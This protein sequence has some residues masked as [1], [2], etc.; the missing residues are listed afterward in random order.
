MDSIFGNQGKAVNS[1]AP[2]D[3]PPTDP[4]LLACRDMALQLLMQS[5]DSFFTT[6]EETFLEMADRTRDTK[7]RDVYLS[8]RTEAQTKR[9]L[10]A[11]EFKQRFVDSFNKRILRMSM[12]PEQRRNSGFFQLET[13]LAELSLVANDEFEENLSASRV[14]NSLKISSADNLK[15]LEQRLARLLPGNSDDTEEMQNP[16]SPDAIC[17]AL[18]A[19]CRQ[20][21]S[22]LD[23]RLVALKSF[24]DQLATSVSEVYKHVNE[25]LVQQNVQPVVQPRGKPRIIKSANSTQQTAQEAPDLA[26]APTLPDVNPQ[27]QVGHGAGAGAVDPSMVTISVPA[28]LA[29]HFEMLANGQGMN[30][31]QSESHLRNQMNFLNQ[32]Q[33]RASQMDNAAA[34]AHAEAA[35][36]LETP[37]N[38][39]AMLQG[40]QWAHNLPQ[41]DAMTLNVVALVFDRL[42]EDPRL[43]DAIKGLIGRLQIPVLKVALIDPT[44]FSRK[45]HP[46]RLLLDKIA[47]IALAGDEPLEDDSQGFAKLAEVVAWLAENFEEDVGVFDS[48]L[49]TLTRYVDEESQK[50]QERLADIAESLAET[51]RAE[52]AALTAESL[53]DARVF[54]RELPPLI[55]DFLKNWWGRA[56]ESAYGHEGESSPVFQ[57]YVGAMEDLLWSVEPK[58]GA[59]DRLKLV[60]LLPTMLK[61]LE[62]GLKDA[63]VNRE[64]QQKFFSELVHCHAAAIRN[65]MKAGS[66]PVGQKVVTQPLPAA[67]VSDA[68]QSSQQLANAA[69]LQPR[70][71]IP[72]PEAATVS[73]LKPVMS[74]LEPVIDATHPDREAVGRDLDEGEAWMP[75]RGEWVEVIVGGDEES[76]KLKLSWISPQGTR[77]LFTNRHG[78]NGQTFKRH[79]VEQLIAAGK[80]RRAE[81]LDNLTDQVFDQLRKVLVA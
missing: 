13:P 56:L 64:T 42:F 54:R 71:P 1:K 70:A 72:V 55:L 41:V 39:V 29:A 79:E 5:F 49:A 67:E 7:L 14:A 19:A 66:V 22:G 65:G 43:T 50:A 17:D 4:R 80:L 26:P 8:A 81:T 48:A 62:Q 37:D 24:E 74:A 11:A 52:I 78:E 61:V 51:E 60:N 16:I 6:L 68:V 63:G 10:I 59:E 32:M 36:G 76:H 77:F 40:T 45:A 20:L 47:D 28:A 18:L 9:G 25:F 75:A 53:I 33:R 30:V 21:E 27:N 69:M 38:L 35:T 15:Q 58:H 34:N 46:A 44:F 2:A 31:P 3:A 23:A 57:R 12:T 73:I